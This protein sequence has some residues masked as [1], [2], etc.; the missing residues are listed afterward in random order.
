MTTYLVGASLRKLGW[1][2]GRLYVAIK[3]YPYWWHHLDSTWIIVTNK[4]VVQVHDHLTQ[5][6]DAKDRLLVVKL[7][8]EAA[9]TGFDVNG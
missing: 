8:R 3:S 9:W 1:D 7:E 2:Y 6:I 5:Y 4:T